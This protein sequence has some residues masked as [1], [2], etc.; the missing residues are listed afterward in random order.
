MR[1]IVRG[2][3]TDPPQA[4]NTLKLNERRR[5]AADAS[6]LA[7]PRAGVAIVVRRGKMSW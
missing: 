6:V 1:L 3:P 4:A 5:K 2:S 7:S